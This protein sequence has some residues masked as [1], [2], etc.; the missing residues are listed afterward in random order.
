MRDAH[1]ESQRAVGEFI[2]SAPD[3][4]LCK[5][6]VRVFRGATLGA[7]DRPV[8]QNLP[9]CFKGVNF[10]IKKRR[11]SQR[12]RARRHV[13]SIN[14]SLRNNF[15]PRYTSSLTR[16]FGWT[17]REILPPDAEF[18]AIFLTEPEAVSSFSQL[19]F[20]TR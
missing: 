15:M 17:S 16:N 14:N 4:K 19:F 5:K 11:G 9:R 2:L 1:C 20:A 3:H 7:H 8:I 13:D 10:E 18:R 12:A 6:K